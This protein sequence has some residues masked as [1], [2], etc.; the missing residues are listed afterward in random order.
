ME[1]RKGGCGGGRRGKFLGRLQWSDRSGQG[2]ATPI[3]VEE[4]GTRVQGFPR[5]LGGLP[6]SCV[7]FRVGPPATTDQADRRDGPSRPPLW[8][9]TCV[10][11]HRGG[12]VPRAA[13]R[14]RGTLA[15]HVLAHTIPHVAAPP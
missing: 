15:E 14:R 3:G 6:F 10:T 12:A 11:R 13:S 8:R 2:R 9:A 4:R 1:P 5:N 7:L